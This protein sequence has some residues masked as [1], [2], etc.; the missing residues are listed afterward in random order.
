MQEEAPRVQKIL[1]EET[2][3]PAILAGFNVDDERKK[4][5]EFKRQGISRDRVKILNQALNAVQGKLADLKWNSDKPITAE[6]SAL[7][8][9]DFYRRQYL[10]A[11]RLV[12]KKMRVFEMRGP[13]F[14]KYRLAN[15]LK[16]AGKGFELNGGYFFLSS[17]GRGVTDLPST[18]D[19]LYKYDVVVM[20]DIDTR[21][22][23]TQSLQML[24]QYVEVG[25]GLIVFGGYF[26]YSASNIRETPLAGILP[27]GID[28]NPFG[29]RQSPET[30]TL[31][32]TYKKAFLNHAPWINNLVSPWYHDLKVKKDGQVVISNGGV[33]WMAIKQAGKGRVIASA[34]NLLGKAGK[35]K[36]VF[37]KWNE[38]PD[39]FWAMIQWS[40]GKCDLS[41]W[42]RCMK[43]LR[44]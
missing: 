34:G 15:T 25:G 38:W 36:V 6:Q 19:D 40:S 44:R 37:Y 1:Q 33:P 27:F 10:T 35:D 5:D 12:D 16:R 13:A 18:I 4:L 28:E 3:Q 9:I 39:F 11:S 21:G 17:Q 30:A 8:A 24:R 14:I 41:V 32:V 20:L 23:A 29:L 22:L 7:D 26:S 2:F 42:E 43:Y 31:A